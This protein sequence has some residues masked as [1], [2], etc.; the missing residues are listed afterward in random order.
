MSRAQTKQISRPSRTVYVVGA[1]LSAGLGYPTTS[2]LLYRMWPRL[3]D[4]RLDAEIARIVRFHHPVFH[5]RRPATFPDI[6]TLLSEIDA[7]LHL[8]ASSRPATGN[9]SLAVLEGARRRLL[10]ELSEWFHALR[11]RKTPPWLKKLVDKICREQAC[12]ISFNYDLVLDHLLFGSALNR[13]SYGFGDG[14]AGPFLLKPHGSLNWYHEAENRSL[15]KD[16]RILLGGSGRDAV[17]VFRRF[18]AP[19]SK[20]D[21][22]YLPLIIPPVYSKRF[23]GPVF[24]AIWKRVVSEISR[25]AE[26]CFL[27][28]SLPIADFHSRFIM[29]CGFFNQEHGEILPSGSREDPTGRSAVTIAKP[30]CS[31]APARLERASP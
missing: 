10:I 26:V 14:H 8:F 29:R 20:T 23:D 4:R 11:P 5:A 17:C 22:E 18:R 3:V 2:D 7:N 9:L 28:Y 12:V 27:G 25:A 19:V 24:E 6:E 30:R 13:E 1:G 15:K 16:R 21:R 31:P